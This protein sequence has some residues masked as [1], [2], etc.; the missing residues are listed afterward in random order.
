M[1]RECVASTFSF[2]PFMD[3]QLDITEAPL[4][5]RVQG[6][7]FGVLGL[8]QHETVAPTAVIAIQVQE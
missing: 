2:E 4:M 6:L 5:V 3:L 8:G 7:G 1:R